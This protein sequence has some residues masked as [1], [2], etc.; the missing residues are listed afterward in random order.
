MSGTG[1]VQTIGTCRTISKVALPTM[2]S[3]TC[4]PRTSGRCKLCLL[5]SFSTIIIF[6]WTRLSPEAT[7]W[8]LP[9]DMGVVGGNSCVK[10]P[11]RRSSSSSCIGLCRRPGE[12]KL[13]TRMI[14][15]GH[16]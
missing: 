9:T 12:L 5:G 2:S 11:V 8:L 16:N 15:G 14:S 6:S 1:C 13:L 3:P 4:R 7:P 10:T